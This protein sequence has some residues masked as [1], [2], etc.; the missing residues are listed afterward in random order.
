[1][2]QESILK[3]IKGLM[4]KANSTDS[5][6]EKETF[7]MKAQEL[8]LKYN[9]DSEKVTSYE[10]VKKE[11]IEEEK[12]SYQEEWEINLLSGICR[13]N[14]CRIV[15]HPSA[16]KISCIGKPSNVNVCLYLFSFFRNAILELSIKAYTAF[17]NEVNEDGDVRLPKNHKM[18]YLTS[19]IAGAVDGVTSKMSSQMRIAKNN[20][21]VG[22]MV[23][24]SDKELE[25][26]FE[27]HYPRLGSFRGSRAGT[28]NANGYGRG[29]ADGSNLNASKGIGTKQGLLN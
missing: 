29:H 4:D 14:F 15:I 19:Y 1:M 20:S 6:A 3:K 5:M 11:G 23:I 9:L 18:K 12:I 8:L 21:D 2:E 7:M 10:Q 24:N 28:V 13:N 16:Q 25:K 26:Y 27:V 17:L 22:L